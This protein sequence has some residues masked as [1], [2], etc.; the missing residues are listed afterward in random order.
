LSA[1]AKK[2][3]ATT[4]LRASSTAVAGLVLVACSDR[5]PAVELPQIEDTTQIELPEPVK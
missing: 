4:L 5:E 1:G 2:A 3:A